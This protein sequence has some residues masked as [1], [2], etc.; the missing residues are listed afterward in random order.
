MLTLI[1][2]TTF[3]I[4]IAVLV[5][6]SRNRDSHQ[7]TKLHHPPLEVSVQIVCGDCAGSG[8]RPR[9]TLLTRSGACEQ[10]GGTSYVLASEW[11][12]MRLIARK[13]AQ[14][15]DRPYTPARVLSF[16]TAPRAVRRE[17]VAV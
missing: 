8:S 13:G 10:C 11:A 6:S 12:M 4:L 1:A 7:L 5:L 14:V 15:K 17:K 3:A 16:E 2:A 9:R